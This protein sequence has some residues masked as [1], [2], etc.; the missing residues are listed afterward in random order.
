VSKT[1]RVESNLSLKWK[2]QNAEIITD[3][4]AK[5]QE[6]HLFL[7]MEHVR[8]RAVQSLGFEIT[9]KID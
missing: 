9:R 8:N 5:E 6:Y 2:C 4:L 7:A 3:I 1:K